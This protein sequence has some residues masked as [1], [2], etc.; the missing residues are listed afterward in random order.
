MNM[1]QHRIKLLQ[2]TRILFFQINL[3]QRPREKLVLL[4]IK[5][6]NQNIKIYPFWEHI[7]FRVVQYTMVNGIMERDK[8]KDNKNGLMVQFMR[9]IGKMEWL[10]V[11]VD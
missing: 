1:H 5:T 9:V 3:L 10:M 8:D 2:L 6:V 11:E 7:V 4:V